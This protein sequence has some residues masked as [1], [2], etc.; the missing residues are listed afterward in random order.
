[1]GMFLSALNL[2][3]DT[4]VAIKQALNRSMLHLK[5]GAQLI[6]FNEAQITSNNVIKAESLYQLIYFR[7]LLLQ[8]NVN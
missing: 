2:N 8:V 4:R 7:Y 3:A 6:C 1:M 5:A